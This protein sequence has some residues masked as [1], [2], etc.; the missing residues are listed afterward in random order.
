M[1]ILKDM[2]NEAY[3]IRLIKFSTCSVGISGLEINFLE[4]WPI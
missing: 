2:I 4:H 3:H 1:K